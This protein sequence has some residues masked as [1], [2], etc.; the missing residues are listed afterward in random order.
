MKK[1]WLSIVLLVVVGC[2][3]LTA[4]VL[5]K[6]LKFANPMPVSDKQGWLETI[7]P[8]GDAIEKRTNGKLKVRP[9]HSGSLIKFADTPDAMEV[10]MADLAYFST[11][12]APSHFPSWLFG[13]VLDP[14][15]SP[16][17]PLEGVMVANIMYD[18]FPSF[19]QELA[20]KN[21]IVLLHNATALLSMISKVEVSD[22]AA[23]KGKRMRIFAGE[24]HAELTKLQ[25]ASP[26]MT[27]WPDVY[28]SLD[29]GI[30]DCMVTVT[31]GMRDL[32][33]YEV[34]QYLYLMKV[35]PESHW[36]A[37]MN[38]SYLTGFNLK[39]FK[40]LPVEQRVIILEEAKKTEEQYAVMAAEKLIP[41][42]L[43]EMKKGGMKISDWSKEDV[44]QW[45]E[46]A[47]S[48]YKMASDKMTAKN[49]PGE[50]MVK[51][52]LELTK[53]SSSELRKLYEKAWA[54]RINW[55]KNL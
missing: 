15:T 2:I 16:R 34:S 32:K 28:E 13:G 55:A 23:L 26:V 11:M 36:V 1:L 37:P 41:S 20:A 50:Q 3:V 31:T 19:Q 29:K 40:R 35:S 30:V 48:V 6:T 22:M 9:F 44:A 52:Y 54:N 51:R 8:W 10:G 53:T 43:D 27:P 21:M 33:L 12:F 5:A 17:S 39:T 25:G 42:A 47:K 24:F 46:M 7:K 4:P 49:L 45:G 38:A 14:V 18:E